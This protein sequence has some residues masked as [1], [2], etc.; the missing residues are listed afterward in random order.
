MKIL[1]KGSKILSKEFF[2]LDTVG[3][4]LSSGSHSPFG[5]PPISSTAVSVVDRL[6]SLPWSTVS[7]VDRLP[8]LPWLTVV[9]TV[10]VVERLPRRPLSII[11]S[12]ALLL[13]GNRTL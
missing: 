1:S 5:L 4:L 13:G 6:P 10:S 7:V 8:R 3:W 11:A 12:A 9:M 2:P